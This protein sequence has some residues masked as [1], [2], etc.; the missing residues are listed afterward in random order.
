MY[1]FRT[2]E[3]INSRIIEIT[4]ILAPPVVTTASAPPRPAPPRPAP[5]QTAPPRPSPYKN[6]GG[7][8]P[9]YDEVVAGIDNTG[10]TVCTDVRIFFRKFAKMYGIG[11]PYIRT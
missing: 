11:N 8:P 5:P 7:E 9:S 1:Y 3:H 4:D 2:R 10:L 6:G